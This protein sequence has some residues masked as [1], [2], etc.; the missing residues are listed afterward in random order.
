[1]SICKISYDDFLLSLKQELELYLGEDFVVEQKRVIKN[2]GV[3]L[4]GMLIRSFEEPVIPSI[5]VNQ[6]YDQFTA[7][8]SL[9][10]IVEEIISIYQ[11]SREEAAELG[12][13]FSYEFSEVKYRITYRLIHYEKN[14][15]LL[16]DVPHLRFLDLAI[17]FHC[18][19]RNDEDG[20][21]ALRITKE[22]IKHWG[23]PLSDL[24]SLA[25]E[26]TKRLFPPVLRPMEEV[27]FDLMSQNNHVTEEEIQDFAN[28]NRQCGM[29]VLTNS[30]GI[31]GAAAMLYPD[32]LQS[33]E[34]KIDSEFYILPSSIHEVILVPCQYG[35]NNEKERKREKLLQMVTE[36]N[37]TQVATEEV[38]SNNVYDN[39]Q[40]I[41]AI[42]DL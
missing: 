38:L 21:G 23:I 26:N 11:E 30:K 4:D 39:V 2:N 6:Y 40:I 25:M 31:N 20:I 10:T 36:I 33:F 22:H 5:Y 35:I 12:N 3:V 28:Q 29:Y 15:E 1:M 8:R 37:E 41:Q 27:V 17:T 34:K 14:R 24:W 32:I 7:G 13:H 18:L 19:V 9:G 42:R 16:E